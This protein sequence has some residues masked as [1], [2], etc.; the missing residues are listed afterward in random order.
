MASS[1][2]R[3]EL[4]ILPCVTLGEVEKGEAG[5]RSERD[6]ETS[7]GLRWAELT[8]CSR[9]LPV[10]PLVRNH[11]LDIRSGQ[12]AVSSIGICLQSPS[13]CK[14]RHGSLLSCCK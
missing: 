11:T 7:R 6:P 4:M 13:T 12:C 2:V 3:M 8:L 10:R 14:L 9:S 5:V 1:L